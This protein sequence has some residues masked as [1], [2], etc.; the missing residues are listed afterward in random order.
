ASGHDD[1]GA[2]DDARI[3]TA[4]QEAEETT[5]R[6]VRDAEDRAQERLAEARRRADAVRVER[7]TEAARVLADLA[8]MAREAAGREAER[9]VREAE[10]EA[11]ALTARTRAALDRAVALI[12]GRVLPCSE[13]TG[14]A[15]NRS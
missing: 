10:A 7:E 6:L 14:E 4:I 8:R 2:T 13:N 9:L 15:A 3:L 1:T 11:A 12:I 5:R